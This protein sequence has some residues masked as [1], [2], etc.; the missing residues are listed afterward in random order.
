MYDWRCMTPVERQR[1]LETRLQKL[2]PW[3]SPPHQFDA[4]RKRF[5]L[6]AT[7]FNHEPII[8]YTAERLDQFSHTLCNSASTHASRIFAWCVLPNHYHLLLFS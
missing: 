1:A 6:S 2:H 4:K 5:L 3:H 7:C 8:A